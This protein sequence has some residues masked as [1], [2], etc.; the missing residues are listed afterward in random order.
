MQSTTNSNSCD[1]YC[2]RLVRCSYLTMYFT[3]YGKGG[4][5]MRA[6]ISD[7]LIVILFFQS[8]SLSCE[9]VHIHV[10]LVTI[11]MVTSLIAEST[12]SM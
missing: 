9:Y 6:V 11:S 10:T 7:I 8:E 5:T 4:Q 2:L 12:S 3:F 1:R